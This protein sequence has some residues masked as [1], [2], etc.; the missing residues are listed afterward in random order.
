MAKENKAKIGRIE[1]A[2]NRTG[3]A[4]GELGSRLAEVE[5]ATNKT[6]CS[7]GELGD[8]PNKVEIEQMRRKMESRKNAMGVTLDEIWCR[9]F[10]DEQRHEKIGIEAAKE[11]LKAHLYRVTGE[12]QEGPRSGCEWRGW[13]EAALMKSFIRLLE[14]AAKES[15]RTPRAVAFRL[16]D[17]IMPECNI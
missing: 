13:E 1:V 10:M 15:G 8:R 17:K 12:G 16:R 11:H 3:K 14:A 4:L 9:P 5:R 6:E 2:M 7:L